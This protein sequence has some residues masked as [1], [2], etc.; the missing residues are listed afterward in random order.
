MKIPK[1]PVIVCRRREE[2]YRKQLGEVTS[3]YS[4]LP[5]PSFIHLGICFSVTFFL[6]ITYCVLYLVWEHWSW[7]LSAFR[8]S[9]LL[10]VSELLCLHCDNKILSWTIKRM[11]LGKCWMLSKFKTNVIASQCSLQG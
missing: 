10:K 7:S 9:G 11:P 1:E 2:K 8:L 3:S 6:R 5:S 4:L